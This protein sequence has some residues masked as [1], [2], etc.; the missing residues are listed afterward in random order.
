[1]TCGRRPRSTG[2]RSSRSA[3]MRIECLTSSCGVDRHA[4]ARLSTARTAVFDPASRPVCVA[5]LTPMTRRRRI[6]PLVVLGRRS[7]ARRRLARVRRRQQQEP[8]RARPKT[9]VE[10]R[11]HG[12]APYDIHFDV[13]DDQDRAGPARRSRSM[14]EGAIEHTLQ[15]RGHRRFEL[16][17]NGRQDRQRHGHARAR[18]PTSYECT[19]AGHAGAGHEGQRWSSR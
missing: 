1:M 16:K 7:S 19:V 5:S 4:P 8:R 13:G 12:R 6:M 3:V 15:D 14:N 9:A 2:A 17:A 18:A 10:R 11:D